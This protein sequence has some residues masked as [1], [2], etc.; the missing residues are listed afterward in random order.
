MPISTNSSQIEW[1]LN[2]DEPWTRYRT[3]VDLLG[4][5]PDHADVQAA[6]AAMLAH[7]LV[8]ELVETAVSWPGYALKNHKDA[9][10][11]LYALSTLADFGLRRDDPG[12]AAAVDGILAHQS[13]EGAFQT[14]VQLYKSF[15]G[16]DGEHWVWMNCDAPTLLYTL[17]KL[18]LEDD[19]R[20]QTAVSHLVS[21]VA[22]GG[23]GC[24]AAPEL[25]S[26][27]GPGR[28]SDPCPI[29]NVY[30]LKALAEIPAL[31]DSPA[32]HAG[33]EMLLGHWQRAAERKFYLFGVGSDYR[34][35]KYPFVW[36]DILHVTEVL[37]RFSFTHADPRLQEMIGAITSQ[38]DENGRY[39]PASMY[40]A[41]KKWSFADKKR[42]SPWLTFLV[43]RIEKRIQ[44]YQS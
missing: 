19:P 40:T 41:W 22:E 30:A 33:A 2:T 38:A 21:L 25:G 8:Q 32:V 26:F 20:V 6:R 36:Y 5:P 7:P 12:V 39:T 29:A 14:Q 16:V 24:N 44:R 10:H 42:P 13:T 15:G 3:L 37:S 11:P 43:L 18:G 27:R 4:L 23:W 31:A 28:K 1:L 17:L 34:K 35:L 9:R